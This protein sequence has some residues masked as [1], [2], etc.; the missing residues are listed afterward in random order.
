MSRDPSETRD[1][2]EA[3]AIPKWLMKNEPGWSKVKYVAALTSPSG[4]LMF[5]ILV[6]DIIVITV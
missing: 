4:K 5:P 6:V 1:T 2:S 3:E